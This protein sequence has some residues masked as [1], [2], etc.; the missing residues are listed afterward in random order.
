M[1]AIYIDMITIVFGVLLISA[2]LELVLL[3]KRIQDDDKTM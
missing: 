3:V 2:N 1:P